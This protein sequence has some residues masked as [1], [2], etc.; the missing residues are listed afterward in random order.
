[1][2]GEISASRGQTDGLCLKPTFVLD[3]Q[4]SEMAPQGG[5]PSW[6]PLVFALWTE[7]LTLSPLQTFNSVLGAYVKEK[8]MTSRRWG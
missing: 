7:S 5:L 8:S 6:H 2:K 1:M 4:G 3:S